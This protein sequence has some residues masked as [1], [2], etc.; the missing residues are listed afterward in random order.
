MDHNSSLVNLS[1]PENVTKPII[2][3]KIQEAITVAM[4]GA[5]KIIAGVVHQICN[6]KVDPS[7]GNI[8]TSYNSSNTMLW[9]DYHVTKLL[10][11]AIKEELSK[12][13]KEVAAPVKDE[14][15]KQLQSK[16]GSQQIATALLASLNDSFAKDYTSKIEVK[17]EPK[18]TNRY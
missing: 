18:Q 3:A 12:Q 16:K 2:A 13:V 5:D 11:D 6:T 7:T 1:I 10:Q 17:F 8:N 9:M 4:G 14:L 15:I